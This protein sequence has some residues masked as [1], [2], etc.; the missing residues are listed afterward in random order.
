MQRLNGGVDDTLHLTRMLEVMTGETAACG[1]A[2]HSLSNRDSNISL[3][4]ANRG[5]D[6]SSS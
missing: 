2:V 1:T 6:A 4:H 5:A 3:M